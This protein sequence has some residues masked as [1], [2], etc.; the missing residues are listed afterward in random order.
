MITSYG[1]TCVLNQNID[2]QFFSIDPPPPGPEMDYWV[3]G[4]RESGSG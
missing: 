3:R 4:E 1:D 2:V